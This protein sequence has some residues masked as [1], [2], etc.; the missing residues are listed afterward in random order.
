MP[1]EKKWHSFS[2][3]TFNAQRVIYL[4]TELKTLNYNRDYAEEALKAFNQRPTLSDTDL[5]QSSVP[6]VH[7]QTQ[8]KLSADPPIL[9]QS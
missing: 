8:K 5:C 7:S 3:L 2:A 4:S 6:P 9:Y 1:C